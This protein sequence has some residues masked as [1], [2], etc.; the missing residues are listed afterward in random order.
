MQQEVVAFR[1]LEGEEVALFRPL[2]VRGAVEKVL[3]EVED[4]MVRAVWALIKRGM[5]EFYAHVAF[6]TQNEYQSQQRK[7]SK[8]P[9]E[10]VGGV[11]H[12]EALSA[13]CR[14][15]LGSKCQ[16]MFAVSMIGW[17]KATE[18]CFSDALAVAAAIADKKTMAIKDVPA[19]KADEVDAYTD[20]QIADAEKKAAEAPLDS[21]GH[22][23]QH[24]SRCVSQLTDLTKL[25][26]R[27]LSA[28]QR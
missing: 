1:S 18:A 28:L 11:L 15:I 2:K 12:S 26:M 17:C 9:T 19:K 27:P 10:L 4:A 3:L 8:D 21:N 16:A 5:Q 22:M 24:Y 7:I 13:R 14:W 20:A 23:R 6:E 25:L